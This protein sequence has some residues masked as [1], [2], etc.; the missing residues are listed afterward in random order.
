MQLYDPGD[1]K[2]GPWPNAPP[3]YA[4]AQAQIKPKFF[5][6]L[7]PNQTRKTWHD[8]QIC[9]VTLCS[10]TITDVSVQLTAKYCKRRQKLIER[11]SG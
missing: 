3:K 7:G 10:N 8:L 5:S 11:A 9:V 4:P 6:T 2:G 1:P